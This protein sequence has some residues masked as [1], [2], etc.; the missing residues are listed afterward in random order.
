MKIVFFLF[1]LTASLFCF[2]LN[3]KNFSSDFSQSVSS[4]DSKINYSGHFVLTQNKAFWSYDKPSKK[5]IYIDKNQ[6]TIVEHDLEQ[7]IF[8]TLDK[9]PNLSEIFK[10][11]KKI[12]PNE[13]E[14]KYEDI[15]Y[16][17][18]LEND[19][20]KNISYK[21]EFE[22]DIFI[23]LYKQSRNTKINEAIFTPKI[24]KDYDL[25]Y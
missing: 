9:T 21:D 22:N 15:V 14:A 4:K 12:G 24:P 10:L 20:V 6:I 13:F 23:T 7:V 18:F 1:S 8:S 25:V 19:E 3:F 11:A 16:K 2:N 17:I 5:E